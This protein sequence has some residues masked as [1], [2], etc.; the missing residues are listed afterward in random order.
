MAVQLYAI[1]EPYRAVQMPAAA[2][3]LDYHARDPKLQAI[4]DY[5]GRTL[6]PSANVWCE[7]TPARVLSAE[8]LR[9]LAR[10]RF[11]CGDDPRK[12]SW[13]PRPSAVLARA[14]SRC[15]IV[16]STATAPDMLITATWVKTSDGQFIWRGRP[17][18]YMSRFADFYP[19]P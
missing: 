18:E 14:L 6:C 3:L 16:A 15:G 12:I 4:A 7:D 17:Q 2:E 9:S 19:E 10:H 1:F 13:A 5:W 8:V 11:L